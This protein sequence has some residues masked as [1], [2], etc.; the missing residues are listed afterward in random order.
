MGGCNST[1][2]FDYFGALMSDKTEYSYE[3]EKGVYRNISSKGKDLTEFVEGTDD[4]ATLWELFNAVVNKRSNGL[5]Y[6]ERI[7][8]A[9]GVKGDYDFLTCKQ[10][11]ERVARIIGG[12]QK[13]FSFLKKGSKVGIYGKNCTDWVLAAIACWN[14][15]WTIVP[16]YDTFGQEAVKH[17]I[18]H[19]EMEIILTTAENL[20]KLSKYLDGDCPSIQ[21]V[22]TF[23]NRTIPSAKVL[24]MEAEDHAMIKD[25]EVPEKFDV[26]ICSLNNLVDSNYPYDLAQGKAEREDLA[27]IMYTSG[28]TGLPKGVMQTH[29][30]YV[31]SVGGF[32][33]QLADMIKELTADGGAM[34]VPSYLPLAHA[35][36]NILQMFVLGAGGRIG[37]Y[38]GDVRKLVDDIKTLKP[39][40]MAGVPRVYQRM[41]QVIRQN[42]DSK[43]GIAKMLINRALNVQSK[44]VLKKKSRSGLYD[45]LVF[46]KVKMAF[47]GKLKYMITG[48]APIAP[49]LLTFMKTNCGIRF[50]EGYG[51]TETAAAH[52]VMDPSDNNCGT[53]GPQIPCAE[54][55]LVSVGELDYTIDDKPCPR[56][57]ICLRGPHVFK[58]Y[59]K[60][61]E[62]TAEVLDEDGWF[63][64]GDIGR[65]NPNGT[66]SIIDRKKNIFKLAQGEYVAAEKIE[67]VLLRSDLVG[68][69]FIYGDSLQSFLVTIVTPD[70]TTFIPA[71]KKLGLEVIPYGEEGWKARFQ[72]LCKAP[73][74]IK[75]VLTDLTALGT[76]AKLMRFEL[77]KKVYLEGEVNELNQGFS[78]E[79]DLLTA[80]FKTKRPQMKKHYKKIIDE[81]YGQ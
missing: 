28:T 36:E 78:V 67:N 20:P 57:E 22:I 11:A 60:D 31:S 12:M 75:M 17:V 47:G 63:H 64:S 38:G 30:M 8:N 81:M 2:N 26:P 52:T 32:C 13:R 74:A 9:E 69:I 55:K 23:G 34:I 15:G 43:K 44:A 25:L 51:L 59:Y 16:I 56:G 18:N 54:T 45:K 62:K 7:P 46:S 76:S 68:Q 80:T 58:G 71:C 49:A 79:N 3:V 37:F 66:I 40:L 19:S 5:M 42:F 4:A 10:S 33:I 6:G 41:E 21:G 77:P 24:V 53:I 1:E 70:P 65:M 72:E 48:S 14:Q 35:F 73:E 39:T 50:L 61:P 29:R 27:F